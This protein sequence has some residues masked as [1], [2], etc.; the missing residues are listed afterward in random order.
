MA[1]KPFPSEIADVVVSGAKPNPA[2]SDE[3]NACTHF[4][5]Y[6][7]AVPCAHCGKM[8]RK[9]WTYLQ[10]FRVGEL[11]AFAVRLSDKEYPPLTPV[12]TDHLLRPTHEVQS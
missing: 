2:F 8:K 4:L 12:C 1:A 11:V 5:Q 10:F 6:R 9:H 7:R 3:M